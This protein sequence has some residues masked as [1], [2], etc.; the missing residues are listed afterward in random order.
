MTEGTENDNPVVIRHLL[1]PDYLKHPI[2][3]R[4]IFWQIPGKPVY[5]I[6]QFKQ[7]I[8]L[9]AVQFKIIFIELSIFLNLGKTA[10]YNI[11]HKR[12]KPVDTA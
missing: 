11:I 9:I 5:L 1:L 7:R 4:V 10:L 6:R 12:C 8:L 2:K 3:L